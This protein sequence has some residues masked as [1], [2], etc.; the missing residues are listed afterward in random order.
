MSK[1]SRLKKDEKKK[2][3]YLKDHEARINR[4]NK[5]APTYAQWLAASPAEKGAMRS[6]VNWKKDNPTA[7]LNR[8]K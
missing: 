2:Q 7:K 5:N 1:T 6:G 4:G 3:A 8:R